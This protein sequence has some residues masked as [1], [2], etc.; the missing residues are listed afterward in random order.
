MAQALSFLHG[1]RNLIFL[2]LSQ[3]S[4]TQTTLSF[5]IEVTAY[6]QLYRR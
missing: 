4:E 1:S 3:H 5:L 6:T 2:T